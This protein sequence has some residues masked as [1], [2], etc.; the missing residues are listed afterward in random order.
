[1]TFYTRRDDQERTNWLWII[2]ESHSWL[3]GWDHHLQGIEVYSLQRFRG[4]GDFRK[5][6]YR[7]VEASEV[8]SVLIKLQGEV[9][10][11]VANCLP[12]LSEN[13]GSV[14]SNLS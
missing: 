14:Q 7:Q 2:G 9:K 8:E 11:L 10:E 5:K 4:K 1:M 6:G 3:V 13:N 12:D